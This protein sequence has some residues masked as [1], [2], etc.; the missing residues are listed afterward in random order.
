MREQAGGH[1]PEGLL[2]SPPKKNPSAKAHAARQLEKLAQRTD[3]RR[4][5]A[6]ERADA[7]KQMQTILNTLDDQPTLN[8]L[9]AQLKRLERT[10][11]PTDKEALR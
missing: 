10:I 9:R 6:Q 4:Q 1:R 7:V 2:D 5:A 11:G 8:A 3:T